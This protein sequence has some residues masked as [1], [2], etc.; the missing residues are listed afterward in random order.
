MF[1]RWYSWVDMIISVDKCHSFGI[2]KSGTSS[3]QFQPKLFVNNE[4]IPPLKQDDYFTVP[5]HK[6]TNNQHKDDLLSDTKDIMK[7]IS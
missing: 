1:S 3:K 7:K 6:M 2:E 4:L 5:G